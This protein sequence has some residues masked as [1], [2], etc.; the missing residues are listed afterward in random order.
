VPSA[1][2]GV[3][4][5]ISRWLY[6]DGAIFLPGIGWVQTFDDPALR[7]LIDRAGLEILALDTSPAIDN[8]PHAIVRTP[9]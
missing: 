1:R 3:R 9:S 2:G 8:W 7:N 6:G 4:G 5:G